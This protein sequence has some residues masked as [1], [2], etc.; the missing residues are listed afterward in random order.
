MNGKAVE[1]LLNLHLQEGTIV[2]HHNIG[3]IILYYVH[4]YCA[5][6]IVTLRNLYQCS[7]RQLSQ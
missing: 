4:T 1:G 3:R 7:I 2:L 5:V 6:F